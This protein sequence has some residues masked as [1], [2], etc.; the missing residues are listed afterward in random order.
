MDI[1]ILLI[2]QN[3]RNGA[4]S[5]LTQFFTKMTFFG[6]LNTVMV[7]M[8]VVYWSVSKEF[9][10]YLLM[11]FS[12]NR[13]VNGLLKVTACT[14]R[15]WIRDSRIVPDKNAISTATGYSFPSGHTMNAATVYGGI[16]VRKDLSK[17][18]RIVMCLLLIFIAF[19]RI[20]LGVHTPQD[21]LVGAVVG[22]LV[23]WLTQKLMK[24]I[25][26]HPGK[27]IIVAVIGISLA[28]GVAVYAG[29]KSYP[30]DFDASG[31]LLV[32]GTKMANDTFKGV[33]WCSGFLT[34]W[35]LERRFVCFTTEISK[36]QKLM[37]MAS[38]LL[39]YYFISLVFVPLIKTS[40]SGT[41]GTIVSCFLQMIFISFLFPLGFKYIEQRLNSDKKEKNSLIKQ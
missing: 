10:T 38:G 35:V 33:G 6:E 13:I 8:A 40:I 31:N 34:G 28:V 36:K 30:Q 41:A 15:P 27:D 21:I 2:L 22:L 17:A 24:I 29:L 32:D 18:F 23:M 9:G 39:I 5:F 11:G 16:V 37:R 25:A 4:G 14:Y 1:S 7:I 20:F 12:G 19:S 26:N 3:F